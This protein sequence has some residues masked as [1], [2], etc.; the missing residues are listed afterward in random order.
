MNGGVSAVA[1][2]DLLE[3][4]KGPLGIE[5]LRAYAEASGDFNDV[6]LDLESAR[7]AG[8]AN[9]FAHGMLTMS[10]AAQMVTE[11][12]GIGSVRKISVRFRAPVRLGDTILCRGKGLG[13]EFRPM[14]TTRQYDIQVTATN[15]HG[16][17]VLSGEISALRTQAP[18]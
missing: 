15:Q 3:L 6:H 18:P 7:R 11:W 12:A 4:V 8:V 16:E 13:I 10:F 2:V 9:V 5:Q 14:A 1:V 17:L